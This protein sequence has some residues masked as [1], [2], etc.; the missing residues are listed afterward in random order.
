MTVVTRLWGGALHPM[1]HLG[2][3]EVTSEVCPLFEN[4]IINLREL[5]YFMDLN[6]KAQGFI[7]S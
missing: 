6:L 3:N 4:E 2:T 7:V 1:G 5:Y